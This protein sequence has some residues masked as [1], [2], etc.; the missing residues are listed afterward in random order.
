MVKSWL[1]KK[2]FGNF[3]CLTTKSLINYKGI[4]VRT[5]LF[6]DEDKNTCAV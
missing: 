3:M 2:F 4:I 6:V 5:W 1:K